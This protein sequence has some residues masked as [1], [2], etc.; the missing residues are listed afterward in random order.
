MEP[1]PAAAPEPS[2]YDSPP[3]WD[4]F[5]NALRKIAKMPDN[6]MVGAIELLNNAMSGK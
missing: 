5:A 6:K 2:P 3:D 4:S 1:D